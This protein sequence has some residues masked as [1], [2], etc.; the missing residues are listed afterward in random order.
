MGATGRKPVT[1]SICMMV[2]DEEENLKRCL[3]SLQGVADEIIVI[4][5]GSSD[6]TVSL[7]ESFG[8]KVYFHPWEGDFSKHRNQSI[9]YATGDW[10]FIIDAD[11]ELFFEAPSSAP[12]LKEWLA[13]IPE[14]CMSCA[15]ILKDIQQSSQ[16]MRFNS[17]RLFRRGC[18]QF[19][20]IVHNTPVIVQGRPE[21]MFLP[22][23]HLNHYGY[24]LSP[25]KKMQ[26]RVR[27]ES[28]LHK[29]I[30]NDPNDVIA[31]FY[32][33]QLY[34]AHNE[35]EKAAGCIEKYDEI[36]KKTGVKF[37]GSIFCTAFHVYRRLG[38]K[39]KSHEWLMAGLKEYPH[40]LDLLMA[41][42]EFGIWTTNL[43]ILVQGAREFLKIYAEYQQNPI[44]SGNRFTYANTPEAYSYCLFHL[45]MAMFQESCVLL[46]KLFD[47]L[48][49]VSDDFRIGVNNDVNLVFQRF[50]L[51][52]TNLGKTYLT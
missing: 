9:G 48:Q 39:V 29:R 47:S 13:D 44:A 31:Y 33:V 1:L 10:V 37:N 40:D 6:G 11:E 19:Q 30:E 7:A 23:I 32:L 26:K 42:T 21:A 46:D 38:D 3:P 17:V 4:D 25:E 27:S 5:T 12:H 14:T 22:K 18:V 24:D 8:A 49:F 28:L 15:I 51:Q 45:S 41:M 20:G 35:F 43:D 50:G 34:T 52:K 2:K 36:S 16:A